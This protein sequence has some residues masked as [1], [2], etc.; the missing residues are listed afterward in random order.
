MLWEREFTG[1]LGA[2]LLAHALL[3]IDAY[4][5]SALEILIAPQIALDR[6]TQKMSSRD[7]LLARSEVDVFEQL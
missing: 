7:A 4:E 6:W 3:M 2:K 5:H 1:E